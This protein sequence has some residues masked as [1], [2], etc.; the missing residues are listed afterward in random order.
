MIRQSLQLA[1]LLS[2][3]LAIATALAAQRPLGI[4]EGQ[5]DVGTILH[6]GSAHYD[7]ATAAY[8]L[9]GSGDNLW[10][11]EDDFHFVWKKVSGDFAL[12]ADIALL[13]SGGDPHRKAV[14]MVRQTLDAN[15]A[16]VV[17]AVHGDGL[18]SL[19]W[20]AAA[21]ENMHEVQANVKAPAT[22]RLEKHGDFFYAFVP[23]RLAHPGPGPEHV[24]GDSSGQIPRMVPPMVPSGAST[25]V[26]FTAPFYVGIGVCA[27]NKDAVQQ[28]SFTNLRFEPLPSASAAPVLV[29]ALETIP[30]AS[31]DR[32]VEYAAVAHFEAPNWTPD[33]SA[34]LFN[35]DG[36][37]RRLSLGSPDSKVDPGDG[38]EVEPQ[39]LD[40]APETHLNNDHGLSPDGSMLA[41]SDS[42]A[43]DRQSRV[44]VVPL[45]GGTP[46]RLTPDGPSYWHGW[47]PDGKTLAFT[48]ERDGNFDIYT[49][50]VAGGVETRLT[51]APGLD[52]GPE[53]SP[54][55]ATIYFN[56]E[57]TGRM[58]IWRM[59]PD[60][61]SQEQV[62]SDPTNDW[63]PHLSPDGQ[64]MV[65]LAYA[66]DVNGH[67][68]NQEV[69]LRLMSMADG[70]VHVLTRLFGGQGTINV[71]SWSPDSKKI[72]FV[73]YELLPAD[74]LDAR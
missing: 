44:Y 25:Q 30:I 57:R 52:D 31:T 11:A 51:T 14:L 47:S 66:P 65:F 12:T 3:S 58:Q 9:T 28:A 45:A 5:Q 1:A 38:S 19:Q 8:L 27:H 29:S 24:A 35:Q 56:S 46:R 67:P 40:T 61:S 42:S 60:G 32:H 49:V 73:S 41:F 70:K 18:T 59:K 6:P 72:A 13:G 54:D 26:V 17:L 2:C 43:P 39:V 15:S 7:P 48:G 68:P 23:G 10:W 53:Y 69:E 33:G 37:L 21:G 16:T 34:L 63:F 71:P 22:V 74:R 20:R 62:I 55:G 4:F 64:W 36:T 50:P